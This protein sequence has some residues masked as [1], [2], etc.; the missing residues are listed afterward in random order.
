MH[1]AKN[2]KSVRR[3]NALVNIMFILMIISLLSIC[4][5]SIV[6]NNLLRTSIEYVYVDL[7][8]QGYIED[9]ISKV[10]FYLKDN[11]IDLYEAK[12]NKEKLR[13]DHNIHFKYDD[14]KNVFIIIDSSNGRKEIKV[15]NKLVDDSWLVVPEEQKYKF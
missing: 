8:N 3:G 15:R 4:T 10:N 11:N 9:S 14:I 6:Y 1:L 2:I 7:Y 13:I 12:A 5:Y